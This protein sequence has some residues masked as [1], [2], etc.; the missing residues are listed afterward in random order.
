MLS[1]TILAAAPFDAPEG[2]LHAEESPLGATPLVAAVAGAV[3]AYTYAQAN[4]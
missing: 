1:S 4:G 3:A 2:A